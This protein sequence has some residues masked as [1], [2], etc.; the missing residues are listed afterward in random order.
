MVELGAQGVSGEDGAE[1]SGGGREAG[2]VAK[3]A[4]CVAKRVEHA[5]ISPASLVAR[6]SPFR[7]WRCRLNEAEKDTFC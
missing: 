6:R 5:Q 1:E 3:L 2:A 7:T 4:E